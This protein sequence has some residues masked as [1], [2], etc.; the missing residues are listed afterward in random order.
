MY[1]MI[2]KIHRNPEEMERNYHAVTD[3]DFLC[4]FRGQEK[5]MSHCPG[6]VNFALGQNEI[7]LT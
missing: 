7:K 6:Q 2:T 5:A 1:L 4:H 3:K